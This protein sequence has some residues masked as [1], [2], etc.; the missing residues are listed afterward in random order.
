[1]ICKLNKILTAILRQ[2]RSI[3]KELSFIRTLAFSVQ[4][5]GKSEDGLRIQM[6]YGV[7]IPNSFDFYE[8]N[9]YSYKT[10]CNSD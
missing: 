7:C 8:N 6:E 5:K 4:T 1:M 9:P 10:D 3:F 2:F